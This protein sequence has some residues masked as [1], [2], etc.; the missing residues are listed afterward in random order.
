M[1]FLATRSFRGIKDG[2]HPYCIHIEAL[3]IIKGVD[4]ATQVTI[5]ALAIGPPHGIVALA[6]TFTMLKRGHHYLVNRQFTM[7]ASELAHG[8]LCAKQHTE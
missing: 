3:D 2:C 8:I 7:V 1:Q 5:L 6:A 4:D